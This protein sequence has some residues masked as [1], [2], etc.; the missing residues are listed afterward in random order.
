ME[1]ERERKRGQTSS[2][3]AGVFGDGLRALADGVLGELT[4]KKK[5]DSGLDLPRSDRRLLVVVRQ[6][7]GLRG[8]AL[9]DVVDERVHDGHSLTGDASVGVDLLQH[10]VDVDAVGLTTTTVALLLL[11][12]SVAVLALPDLP[13]RTPFAAALFGAISI[14][15]DQIR[16][17]SK[18]K[19][20]L[21]RTSFYNR[22]SG[23]EKSDREVDLSRRTL[24]DTV[25]LC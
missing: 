24:E 19:M 18:T 23:I 14:S 7:T 13:G 11:S 4:G 9:E 5:T 10:L 15:K 6:A 16:L 12:P 3:A 22:P 17:R 20:Q 1:R 2:L 25:A 21:Q 8:N